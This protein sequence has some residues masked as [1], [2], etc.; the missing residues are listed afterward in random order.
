MSGCKNFFAECHQDAWVIRRAV[1]Q[2]RKQ[3]PNN[4]ILTAII[5][6]EAM[7]KHPEAG[8][9]GNIA[10]LIVGGNDTTRNSMSGFCPGCKTCSPD[11]FELLRNDPS[12][13]ANAAQEIIRAITLTHM[14]RTTTR[15]TDWRQ[16]ISRGEKIILW[17]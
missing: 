14:R 16:I 6:S 5:H 2:E 7:G 13:V 9:A 3:P 17:L 1:E 8:A 11:Q 4:K 12:L 10:L 15:E